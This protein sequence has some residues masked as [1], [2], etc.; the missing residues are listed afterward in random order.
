MTPALAHTPLSLNFPTCEAGLCA[1][2]WG[3]ED[4]SVTCPVGVQRGAGAYVFFGLSCSKGQFWGCET[5]QQSR[6]GQGDL[7]VST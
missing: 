1:S 5:P 2:M 7:A 3:R 6:S 4:T